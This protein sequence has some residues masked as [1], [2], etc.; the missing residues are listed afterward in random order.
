MDLPLRAIREQIAAAVQLVVQIA[1]F[2]D[3]SRK[4][5]SICEVTG[6]QQD[7]ISM[8]ELFKYV[9]KGLDADGQRM[10]YHCPMGVVPAW[11]DK[12]KERGVPIDIS[13]FKK[14]KQAEEQ[15]A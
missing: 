15:S 12:F 7:V 9:D 10:G 14:S 11:A 4:V 6:I 13:I 2:S 1:R 3:G 8:Q 5:V